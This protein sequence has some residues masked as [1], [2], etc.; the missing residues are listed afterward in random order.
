MKRTKSP[1]KRGPGRPP[2]GQDNST[3]TRMFGRVSDADWKT[4]THAAE[5]AGKDRSTWMLEV[6]L[7]AAKQQK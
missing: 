1:K 2:T 4:I 5:N 7:N 3:P 6:L